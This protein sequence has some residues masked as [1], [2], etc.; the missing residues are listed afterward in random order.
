MIQNTFFLIQ[1]F[2]FYNNLLWI[3]FISI[4]FE[5]SKQLHL[6]LFFYFLVFSTETFFVADNSANIF[7]SRKF[8]LSLLRKLFYLTQDCSLQREKTISKNKYL[9]STCNILILFVGSHYCESN[10]LREGSD[11]TFGA[12]CVQTMTYLFHWNGICN[13]LWLW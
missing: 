8:L 6:H 4:T 13:N 7:F 1:S 5:I 10:I 12:K 9:S 2:P 3:F 11:W